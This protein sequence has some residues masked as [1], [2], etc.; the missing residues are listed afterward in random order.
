MERNTKDFYTFSEFTFLIPIKKLEEKENRSLRK[1]ALINNRKF[2]IIG[3]GDYALK[4]MRL[5]KSKYI[6]SFQIIGYDYDVQ[7]AKGLWHNSNLLSDYAESFLSLYDI[8]GM[9]QANEDGE[10]REQSK[11]FILAADTQEEND[12]YF[13]ELETY[14]FAG[15]IIINHTSKKIILRQESSILPNIEYPFELLDFIIQN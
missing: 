10:E 5:W 14:L 4:L 7:K 3:L 13:K 12:K 6:D 15:D 9:P 8:V 2:A 11:V 1:M